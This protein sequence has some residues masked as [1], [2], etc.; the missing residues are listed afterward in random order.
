MIDKELM[1]VIYDQVNALPP[2]PQIA[3]K[4]LAMLRDPD[5]NIQDIAGLISLDQ[6][7][8]RSVLGWANSAYY[9]LPHSVNSVSQAII[10]LGQMTVRSIVLTACVSGVL[11]R[12]LPG[13]GLERGDLWLHSISVAIGARQLASKFSKAAAEEA[14][15]AG[16][17]CDVGKLG[18]EIGLRDMDLNTP[19]WEK[20]PF[21]AIEMEIFGINHAE[22]GNFI[23]RK[24]M[25]P[26]T[27]CHTIL[28]HHQPSQADKKNKVVTAA[29]HIA[30]LAVMMI[31]VGIGGDGLRYTPDPDAFEVL[32]FKED[33][34]DELINDISSNVSH[35]A[36]EFGMEKL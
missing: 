22:M 19:E 13:Y 23:A 35:V 36:Y 21:E 12:A 30:D 33:Q 29:V 25:L 7:I 4:S 31:G 2:L 18:F 10:Y 16:L 14:Y 11:N 3:H 17:L 9:G 5:S 28:H 1:D 24:W 8:S 6:V 27:I 26:D 20:K 15:F 34:L 32:D